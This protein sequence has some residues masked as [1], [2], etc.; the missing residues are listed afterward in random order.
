[1]AH[2]GRNLALGRAFMPRFNPL[3]FSGAQL[4][5]TSDDSNY[6]ALESGS[7]DDLRRVDKLIIRGALN[8]DNKDASDVTAPNMG[9]GLS[10]NKPV[11]A[12]FPEGRALFGDG[13]NDVLSYSG[14]VTDFNFLHT[15]PWTV[16][17]A[18]RG[19]VDTGSSESLFGTGTTQATKK[20][21]AF[22][23]QASSDRIRLNI[24][25]GAAVSSASWDNAV[26]NWTT[27]THIC[28]MTYDGVNAELF[29][30][31]VSK[32]SRAVTA[33]TGDTALAF[34]MFD[35]PDSIGLLPSSSY[36]PELVVYNRVLTASEVAQVETYLGRWT[37]DVTWDDLIIYSNL[38]GLLGMYYSDGAT[39][40]N[41][42]AGHA[43]TEENSPTHGTSAGVGDANV[44]TLDGVNQ[45]A[46]ANSLATLF[47]GDDA[48]FTWMACVELD[49]VAADQGL[50]AA[51]GA[52]S[53][54]TILKMRAA[55]PDWQIN[56]NDGSAG[57]NVFAG[58][59]DTNW[60]IVAA[61]M[62]QTS[63]T[64]TA[65][66]DEDGVRVAE[67]SAANVGDKTFTGFAMGHSPTDGY[68]AA[69]FATVLVANRFNNLG[70]RLIWQR[71]VAQRFSL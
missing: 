60:R 9:Q 30:D 71:A 48:P 13:G 59:A 21:T 16:A 34:S 39:W 64:G 43:A 31:G 50:L 10:A 32:G 62:R 19:G 38:W 37:L 42:L 15:G 44:M 40:L 68:T 65:S 35:T 2:L 8:P 46:T 47:S 36:L 55:T 22:W 69:D 7:S 28:V 53:I 51:T 12:S 14:D 63:G 56:L 6:Y 29:V 23:R 49:S 1:M 18:V 25:D 66:I 45:R 4:W 67:L 41:A 24:A 54:R 3:H 11:L 52:G 26:P 20:G 70:D 5:V 57:A 61:A 17:W 58:S 27:D 33:A